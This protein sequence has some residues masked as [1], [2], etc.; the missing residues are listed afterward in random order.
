MRSLGTTSA[1]A[2]IA[3]KADADFM[4]LGGKSALFADIDASSREVWN[5]F[6]S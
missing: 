5:Q 3:S 6:L 2:I 4:R 1:I